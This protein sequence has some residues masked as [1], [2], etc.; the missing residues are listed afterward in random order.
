[1]AAHSESLE[2]DKQ[3]LE[4]RNATVIEENRSLLDQLEALNNAVT[5]SDS[6]VTSLQATLASSQREMQRLSNLV[7]R[8]ENLERQLAEF[9]QE[10]V[11]WQSTLEGKEQSERSAVRRWQTAERTLSKLQEQIEQ[12]E[13]EASEERERHAEIVERMERRRTVE[14]ELE[15][16]AGRLKGAAAFKNGDKDRTGTRVVSHF[17]KDILQDNTNLQ[18][19]IVELREMLNTSNEEVENLRNQLSLH[20]PAE[21]SE[22]MTPAALAPKDLGA[23]M[24]RANSQELHVHHHYHAPPSLTKTSSIRRPKKKRNGA[25]VSGH[26]TPPS[27]SSTPRSSFSYSTPTSAAAILQQTSASVPAPSSS[28]KRLSVQSNQTFYSI[29]GSGPSSPQST[30]NRTS[31]IFDR[32]FSDNGHD[33]SRPN[34][35][36]TE[37]PGSPTFVPMH[38][39]RGSSSSWSRTYSAPVVQRQGTL[40][41]PMLDSIMSIEELPK[42]EQQSSDQEAILEDAEPS[43]SDEISTTEQLF[44]TSTPSVANGHLDSLPLQPPQPP[45]KYSFHHHLSQRP[46]PLRRATSHESLLSV[47]GMDIHTL[48]PQASQLLAPFANRGLTSAAVISGTNVHAARPMASSR[49]SATGRSILSGMAA[50]QRQPAKAS[51]GFGSKMGGWMFGKWGVTAAPT[52]STTTTT[53]TGSMADVLAASSKAKKASNVV[54]AGTDSKKEG[55]EKAALSKRSSASEAVRSKQ[56]GSDSRVASYTDTETA[57]GAYFE[58]FG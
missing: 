45:N 56:V 37:D 18:M 22:E 23:E 17:V 34:T 2:A 57:D 46:P 13:R 9:E 55:V 32:V 54:N 47:S 44:S 33:S 16:A 38:S 7:S 28:S 51:G 42:L 14:R 52:T 43:L 3:E 53:S 36:D 6:H 27:G 11:A 12:I 19:G 30:N 35:P 10:Q 39:K 5:E 20:Q 26:S 15:S 4:R 48:K 50:E 41:K 31:S 8:T 1:M 40:S 21:D 29:I 24:N 49:E 58:E 25:L